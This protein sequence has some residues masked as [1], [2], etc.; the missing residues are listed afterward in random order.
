[1]AIN[2]LLHNLEDAI[3]QGRHQKA[4]QLATELAT[5]KIHCSVIQQKQEA[6]EGRICRLNLY[7][8]DKSKSLGPIP[9]QVS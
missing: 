7:I 4:A 9:L 3:S 8:E 5:L 6:L 1:M 2:E